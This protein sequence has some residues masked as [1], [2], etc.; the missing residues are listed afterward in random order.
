MY[1]SNTKPQKF[2]IASD[3]VAIILVYYS[4]HKH[5]K[6]R[7]RF[8]FQTTR[9][10]AREQ[11]RDRLAL[12]YSRAVSRS[13]WPKFDVTYQIF[14]LIFQ[15]AGLGGWAPKIAVALASPAVVQLF[16]PKD[17]ES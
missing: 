5:S 16:E 15:S 17:T 3:T 8:Y 11:G 1:N 7:L 2:E 4:H 12:I 6:N 9:T 10:N 14:P 13:E